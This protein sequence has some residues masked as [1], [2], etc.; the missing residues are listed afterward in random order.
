MNPTI[1]YNILLKEEHP[2]EDFSKMSIIEFLRR[3][4]EKKELPK[5]VAIYG[6]EILLLANEDLRE[7]TRSIRNILRANNRTFREMGYIFLFIPRSELYEDG[8]VYIKIGDKKADISSLF[9]LR[10]QIKEVGLYHADF[11]F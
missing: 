3:T 11:E 7:A 9:G 2:P 6:L 1:G 5:K 8:S 4:R 10:L